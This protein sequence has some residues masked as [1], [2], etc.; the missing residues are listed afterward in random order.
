MSNQK[1]QGVE[2][3]ATQMELTGTLA[4][5]A[6]EFISTTKHHLPGS[7]CK[8]VLVQ[9][10]DISIV[11]DEVVPLI[12]NA[13]K[14]AE[15]EL[16]VEDLILPLSDGHMNL[17]VA[18]DEGIVVA[19]MITEII[20]YP[21]KKILRV[22]TIAG[23]DGHG[24]DKWYGFLPMVEGFALNNNCSSLEAWTRKGMAKKL[25]DWKHS[26]IVI[27]KDLKQRMQ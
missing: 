16:L 14:H 6:K 2:T 13:L 7:N 3:F 19:A 22:I 21:R 4:Q 11:W 10:S 25:K 20:I 27:T 15:G 17:W 24:M 23:K 9:P 18:F 26:Y 5:R 8:V 12:N 1:N